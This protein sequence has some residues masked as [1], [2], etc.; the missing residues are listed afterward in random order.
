MAVG[1]VRVANL[2]GGDV[3]NAEIHNERKHDD[4]GFRTP[5]NIDQELTAQNQNFI[6]S[7]NYENPSGSTYMDSIKN[8]FKEKGIKPRKN[9][10]Y[11]I[12][13]MFSCPRDLYQETV[14]KETGKKQLAYRPKNYLM[15][16]VDWL[17]KRHGEENIQAWSMHLD[18]PG[19]NPHIHVIVTPIRK[20]EVKWKN[21]NGEGI[22][23]EYRLCAKD[24]T[25]GPDKLR[26]LQDDFHQHVKKDYSD[27]ATWYRGTKVEHQTK[28]YSRR[29]SHEIG[30]LKKELE[31]DRAKGL[32]LIEQHNRQLEIYKKEQQLLK[33]QKLLE[34]EKDRR[35][36]KNKGEGWKRKILDNHDEKLIKKESP[37]EKKQKGR[38]KGQDFSMGM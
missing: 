7:R 18:E 1:I 27:F 23:E 34:Q 12:E 10:V 32:S 19:A 36:D 26:Q 11:A 33:E 25:G 5:K 24:F 15:E 37:L 31:K 30:L 13:Y 28:E 29:A 16:C 6:R 38:D 20:K 8:T 14:D 22:K 17:E 2:G 3:G 35:Q 9:S 4:L 21:R